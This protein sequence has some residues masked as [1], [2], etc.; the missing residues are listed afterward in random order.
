MIN[1][2]KKGIELKV[3]KFIKIYRKTLS[4][5]MSNT[6]DFTLVA[7]TIFTTDTEL[8]IDSLTLKRMA[9]SLVDSRD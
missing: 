2:K 6:P 8:G 9:G 7:K 4:K 3:L 5:S 1:Y